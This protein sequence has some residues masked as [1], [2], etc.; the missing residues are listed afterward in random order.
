MAI[1]SRKSAMTAAGKGFFGGI[2]LWRSWVSERRSRLRS[3]SWRRTTA[4][5]SPPASIPARVSRCS[6][7]FSFLADAE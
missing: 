2:N 6:P 3:G 1:Q 5:L 7:A 4:P